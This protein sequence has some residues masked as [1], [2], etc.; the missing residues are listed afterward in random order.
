MLDF[1][2]DPICTIAPQQCVEPTARATA[3]KVPKLAL[4]GHSTARDSNQMKISISAL[5]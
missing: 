3:Q 2:S 4:V 1:E 5:T